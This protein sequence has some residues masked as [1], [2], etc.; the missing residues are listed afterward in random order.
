GTSR[1]LV[2]IDPQGSYRVLLDKYND[3]PFNAPNDLWVD[4]KGGIYFTDPYWGRGKDASCI[5]Y[6][7]PDRENLI[8]AADDMVKPNGVIG[9]ADCTL[10]YVTDWVEKKTYVYTIQEDGMLSNRRLFAPEGDDGMTMDE[11]GNVY[12]TGSVLSVYDPSGNKIETIEVPETPANVIFYGK[13]KEKLFITA[14]TSIY[15]IRMQV[16]G[17]Y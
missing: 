2:S 1:Q 15:S 5:Y 3:R 14:R 11:E 9:T 4:P 7:S 17:L 13:D 10:L 6:L 12:L 16:K 8:L